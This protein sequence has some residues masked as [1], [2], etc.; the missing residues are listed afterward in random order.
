MSVGPRKNM[1]DYHM[2]QPKKRS[3]V[4]RIL[5]ILAG[6]VIVSGVAVGTLTLFTHFFPKK[7]A[8]Q[9]TALTPKQQAAKQAAEDLSAG[10][11]NE[12]MGDTAAA[13]ASYKEA[14]K[15]YQAAGD[16][17]GEQGVQLKLQYLESLSK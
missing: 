3:V 11:K 9:T 6:L 5:L 17:S 13:I 2:E 10:K 12:D 4:K 16:K 15:N 14:L 7:T 1:E 8:E